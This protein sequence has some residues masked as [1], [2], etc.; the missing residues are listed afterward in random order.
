MHVGQAHCA[1]PPPNP[2]SVF[3]FVLISIKMNHAN[4]STNMFETVCLFFEL[5]FEAVGLIVPFLD[6]YAVTLCCHW[7]PRAKQQRLFPQN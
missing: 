5:A 6:I 4:F 3:A 1:A 2:C 7:F